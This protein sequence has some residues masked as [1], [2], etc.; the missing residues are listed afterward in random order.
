MEKPCW[1]KKPISP[2]S[3]REHAR[4]QLSPPFIHHRIHV[5]VPC[6]APP[7]PPKPR[8]ALLH[9]PEILQ[10]KLPLNVKYWQEELHHS[11]TG[12]SVQIRATTSIGLPPL[13][14]PIVI[15]PLCLVLRINWLVL[16]LA[17]SRLHCLLSLSCDPPT[18][19]L[20]SFTSLQLATISPVL[21]SPPGLCHTPVA[22]KILNPCLVILKGRLNKYVFPVL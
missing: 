15:S 17:C 4:P 7:N 9:R 16:L 22:E 18:R 21:K 11:I 12:L 5:L 1:L 20:H 14:H 10:T 13:L 2:P 3:Q 19:L 8:V 6:H